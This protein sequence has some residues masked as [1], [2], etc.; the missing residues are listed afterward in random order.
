MVASTMHGQSR[1]PVCSLL[2]TTGYG[3]RDD[4]G[5]L[6]LALATWISALYEGLKTKLS[7]EQRRAIKPSTDPGSTWKEYHAANRVRYTNDVML[8]TTPRMKAE[9]QQM[10]GSLRDR[11]RK[12]TT[13]LVD[14]SISLP[15]G[16]FLQGQEERPD[17]M[18]SIIV[19][20]GDTPYHGELF[21]YVSAPVAGYS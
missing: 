16:I 10:R 6:V 9:A 12:I 8:N 18:K 14:V 13:E 17:L 21:K 20:P 19:G 1:N 15:E 3:F 5:K 7:K 2:K 4:W 11:M